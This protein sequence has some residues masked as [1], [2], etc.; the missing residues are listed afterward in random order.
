MNM[1]IDK[2]NLVIED[3][4]KKFEFPRGALMPSHRDL[5]H[6][7]P[8]DSRLI[9]NRYLPQCLRSKD[10][11]LQNNQFW[12]AKASLHTVAVRT[13]D[14]VNKKTENSLIFPCHKFS[15]IP[16][17]AVTEDILRRCILLQGEINRK[18]AMLPL[19]KSCP[20]V[21]LFRDIELMFNRIVSSAE[22]LRGAFIPSRFLRNSESLTVLRQ[23]EFDFLFLNAWGINYRNLENFY[24][25]LD[26][27]LRLEKPVFV[28]DAVLFTGETLF[29]PKLADTGVCG[30]SL[31]FV[32]YIPDEP[33][34]YDVSSAVNGRHKNHKTM[35]T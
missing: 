35:V 8:A 11:L 1:K 25:C 22:I 33:T 9:L 16:Y 23:S 31:P 10:I 21:R 32:G 3:N 30:Y 6:L 24:G 28:T 18:I 34:Y 17:D 29:A 13:R 19:F 15:Q 20:S 27:L 7:K 2:E 4:E 26:R 12:S 14:T 5:D